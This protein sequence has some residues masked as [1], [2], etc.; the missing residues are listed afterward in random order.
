MK[1]E[2]LKLIVKEKYGKIAEQSGKENSCC[3]S[4]SFCGSCD[5]ITTSAPGGIS[6]GFGFEFGL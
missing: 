4:S 6:T 3:G 2:D 1:A 5:V